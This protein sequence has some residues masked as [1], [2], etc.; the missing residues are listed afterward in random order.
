M[1]VILVDDSAVFRSA[2]KS[3]MD[4]IPDIE[5]VAEA[6]CGATAI[7]RIKDTEADLV[8]GSQPAPGKVG[9]RCWRRSE[10]SAQSRC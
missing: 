6:D 7:E 4:Q 3:L 2:L 1:R 8:L 5:V 10:N 9:F